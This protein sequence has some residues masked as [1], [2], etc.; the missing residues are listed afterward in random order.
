MKLH[1]C[2]EKR[3]LT[4]NMP[5]ALQAIRLAMNQWEAKTCIRFVPRTN[6]K[7][8]LEFFRNTQYVIKRSNCLHF[9]VS[10]SVLSIM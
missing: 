2:L 3:Y 7:D 9:M 1:H 6:E 8:Y 10:C 4:E 5:S